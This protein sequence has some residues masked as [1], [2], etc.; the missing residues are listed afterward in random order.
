MDN[1]I[2]SSGASATP[3]S[4][5]ASPS[6]GYPSSGNPALAEPATKGGAFWFHQIGEELRAV[7]VAAGLTPS[8]ATNTQLLDAIQRLIDAQSGNYA[9]DTGTAGAYVV[10]LNPAIT[11]YSDGMTVRVKAVNANPGAS[12]LNAGGGVVA[13]ANDV[14]SALVGGDVPAGSIFSATF[15]ASANAFWITSMV[16]SQ[17][18]ARYAMKG[19]YIYIRDE[20]ASGT[21]GGTF[22]S[23]AWQTRTLNTKVNDAGGFATLAAN[24]QVILASGKYR[25]KASAV[26]VYV[27]IHKLKLKNITDNIDYI[28]MNATCYNT[29]TGASSNSTVSGEFTISSPKTFELQHRCSFTTATVGMGY[30]ATMGVSEVYAELEFWKVD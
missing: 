17:G 14:G 16:Q 25:F 24:N 21:N 27:D 15:I 8:T 7:L 26:G 13:L 30:A 19:A 20:R 2:W 29:V 10:A 5:P 3:P 1:R 12:T 6:S 11:A 4:P 18:D 9:L 28:G 22:T 23:G